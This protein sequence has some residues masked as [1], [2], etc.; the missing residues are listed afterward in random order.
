MNR[1]DAEEAL[2]TF[3]EHEWNGSILK[4]TWSSR[5]V[6]IPMRPAYGK[7][8]LLR[9]VLIA[10]ESTNTDARPA[11]KLRATQA[12][13][14][15]EQDP[16]VALSWFEKVS[17]ERTK[18]I[19]AVADRI[20]THGDRFKQVLLEREVDNPQWTFLFNDEVRDRVFAVLT[21]SCPITTYSST[22]WTTAI[23]FRT[24]R[25]P[26]SKKM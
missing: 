23:G 11:K 15:D 16:Q 3:D 6:P 1:A 5:Q 13:S 8:F 14:A 25:V 22:A 9:L 4:V 12:S 24:R 20:K 17:P 7:L 2:R 21:A 26:I 18:F 10:P 19:Q